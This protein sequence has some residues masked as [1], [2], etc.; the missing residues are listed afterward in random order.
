MGRTKNIIIIG[1]AHPIRSGGIT[2]S[3]ERLAREFMAQGYDTSIYT[4]SFQYPNFLFPGTTQFSLEPAPVDLKIK[5]CI[6]SINPLNWLIVGNELKNLKPDIIVIRYW[7]PF[8]GPCFGTIL[9]KIKKNKF[10]R[11]V[12]IAD[13]IIPHEKRTG[14]VAFTKYFVK[15]VDAFIAMSKKVLKDISI[16]VKNKP[17]R[18]VPLPL[19]D[20][21][22]QSVSKEDARKKLGI[23]FEDKVL[24][25]FGFIREYKGLDILFEAMA[26]IKNSIPDLKLLV[27]GEYYGNRKKYEDLIDKLGIKDSLILHTQFI[28]D[29]EVKF[30]MCAADCVVQPYRHATQS[31]VTPVAYHFEKPMIIT[32]VGGLPDLVADKKAGLIAEPNADDLAKKIIE[33]FELGEQHFLSH[34][35]EE[36]KKYSWN[37]MVQAIIDLAAVK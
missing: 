25:F 8:M 26:I 12:C 37:S 5:V 18:F 16:F 31:A 2:S 27:V 11:I 14:D 21:F 4:F 15:P 33:Y 7:L 34:I 32:N 23:R 1:S 35:R 22:G 29:S 13:N 6:N 10:T 17:M 28:A 24:L 20:N 19:Y 9:R 3:N 30:Y 36:K